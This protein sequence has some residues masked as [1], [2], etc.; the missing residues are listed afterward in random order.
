MKLEVI[1]KK[2]SLMKKETLVFVHGVC[3]GA[4]VWTNFMDFFSTRGYDCYALSLRGHCGSDGRAELNTFTLDDYVQDVI[5]ILAPFN[6]DA[7]VIGHSMGGGI[8]QKLIGEHPG[9]AKAAILLASIPPCGQGDE[10]SAGMIE[11]SSK[12]IYDLAKLAAGE[13]LTLEEISQ[14]SLFGGRILIN[15]VEEY[16]KYLQPE[17]QK[18]LGE[19]YYP[20]S[21]HYD[22]VKIPVAVIGSSNDLVFADREL[23][24]TADAYGV[25]PVIFIDLCH[26]MMIDPEWE[27]AAMTILNFLETT[28]Y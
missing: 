17:S 20:I 23:Q 18:A 25:K 6:G 7:I 9:Y 26:D 11:R 24:I 28:T 4:W 1:C 16:C 27:K 5:Q 14:C 12:G 10:V 21:Q 19:L 3:H 22:K 15:E 2:S 8:V 13:S